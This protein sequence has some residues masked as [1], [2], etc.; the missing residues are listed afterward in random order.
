MAKV[1]VDQIRQ[2]LAAID[3]RRRHYERKSREPGRLRQH[4]VWRH[5]YLAHPYLLGAPDER[6]AERF[7]SIFMNVNELSAE[8][9]EPRSD[10]SDG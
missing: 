3:G 4:E 8:G 10:G 7:K 9:K 2:R 6:V 5:T 1:T